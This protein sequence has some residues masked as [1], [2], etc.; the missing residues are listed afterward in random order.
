MSLGSG[1]VVLLAAMAL[2][3]GGPTAPALEDDPRRSDIEI[4]NLA[5]ECHAG[6]AKSCRRLA[7][8][9][10]QAGAPMRA[11]WA[12][13]GHLG[14]LADIARNAADSQIREWA[15][16][17]LGDQ[18]LLADI[19]SSDASEGVRTAAVE[20]I[21]DETLLAGI[22]RNHVSESVR[23]AAVERIS[24][25][26]VLADIVEGD[27]SPI[28]RRRAARRLAAIRTA[29]VERITDQALLAQIAKNDDTD[30]VRRAAVTRL[31][32]PAALAEVARSDPS[33]SIRGLAVEKLTDQ[34]VLLE[35]ARSEATSSVRSAAWTRLA[36]PRLGPVVATGDCPEEARRAAVEGLEALGIQVCG[37]ELGL[38]VLV[39]AKGGSST[40]FEFHGRR[41]TRAR[42]RATIEFLGNSATEAV[43]I[44]PAID[45]E[46]RKSGRSGAASETP[47]C[48]AISQAVR[49]AVASLGDRLR[50]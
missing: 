19:A 46:G 41:H 3:L 21:R 17:E 1:G 6:S 45:Q 37:A 18:S 32:D 25:Q 33:A 35:I 29:A 38:Q 24:N 4:D 2:A 36:V 16:L 11:V 23:S 50:E 39:D 26:A 27:S 12:L 5:E 40:R 15:V 30:E 8:I 48:L 34:T 43:E 14:L 13:S 31:Q 9:A 47:V 49:K 7:G 20:R 44:H 22:A 28:V 10:K 42:A